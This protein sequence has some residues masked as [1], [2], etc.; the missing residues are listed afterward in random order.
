MQA[1]ERE[2]GPAL[3]MKF[4]HAVRGHALEVQYPGFQHVYGVTQSEL[5]EVI[6][7]ASSE[8]E[9]RQLAEGWARAI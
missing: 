1:I 9:A 3:G 2:V 7:E 4:R 6:G 5:A 8:D